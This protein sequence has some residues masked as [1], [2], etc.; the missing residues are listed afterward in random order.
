MT[1][2][3]ILFAGVITAAAVSLAFF[4]Y[5]NGSEEPAPS[6][7][8]SVASKVLQENRGLLKQAEAATSEDHVRLSQRP[9]ERPR[10]ASDLE[11]A[12]DPR[13]IDPAFAPREYFLMEL[14]ELRDRAQ[15]GDAVALHKLGVLTRRRDPPSALKHFHDAAI[16]GSVVSLLHA[17]SVMEEL[18]VQDGVTRQEREALVHDAYAHY[19]A[20]LMMGYANGMTSISVLQQTHR[21]IPFSSASCQLGFQ[22]L[23]V[24]NMQRRQRAHQPLVVVYGPEDLSYFLGTDHPCG[25]ST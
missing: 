25:H 7:Y 14:S 16:N 18:A 15:G 8:R 12:Q 4:R 2:R 20:Y 3:S 23:T 21:D 1:R 19:L 13:I 6:E 24:L 17:A 5:F 22:L 11:L 10:I 9:S